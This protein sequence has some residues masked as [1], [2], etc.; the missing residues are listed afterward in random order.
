MTVHIYIYMWK[1]KLKYDVT[2]IKQTK[3][4]KEILSLNFFNFLGN[5][6]ITLKLFAYMMGFRNHADDIVEL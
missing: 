6:D 1:R 2:F 3:Q 5:I 4:W